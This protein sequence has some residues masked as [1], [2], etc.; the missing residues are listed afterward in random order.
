MMMVK[1][2]ENPSIYLFILFSDNLLD[3]DLAMEKNWWKT[4][5]VGNDA[6]FNS[7][8]KSGKWKELEEGGRRKINGNASIVMNK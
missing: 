4:F 7:M 2:W 6:D 5:A 3:S 8:I 1:F